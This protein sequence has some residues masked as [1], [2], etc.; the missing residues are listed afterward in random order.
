MTTTNKTPQTKQTI[1]QGTLEHFTHQSDFS[2]HYPKKTKDPRTLTAKHFYNQVPSGLVKIYKTTRAGATTALSAQS[3]KHNELF[4][5]VARTNKNLTGTVIE[6]TANII[7][8]TLNI[9]HIQANAFCPKIQQQI[10]KYPT[11][12]KLGFIPLPCNTCKTLPCPIKDT[13]N[14]PL[15]KTNGFALTYSKLMTLMVSHGKNV[16]LLMEKICKAK[17]VIFDEAQTLQEGTNVSISLWKRKNNYEY[18]LDLAP[19][20]K[21]EQAFPA[22]S[23]LL[24]KAQEIIRSAQPAIEGLKTKALTNHHRKHLAVTVTNP[25]YERFIKEQKA[26]KAQ[27]D[28]DHTKEQAQ[29]EALQRLHPDM[30]PLEIRL[31]L[32]KDP[33]YQLKEALKSIMREDIA[34]NEIVKIQEI[35]ISAI[36]KPK[37]YQLSEEQLVTL[38]KLLLIVN[39]DFFTVSYTKSFSGEEISLQAQDTLMPKAIRAFILRLLKDSTQ[40]R[41]IFTTATFG[42]LSPEKLLDLPAMQTYVWGDPMDTSSKLLVVADKFRISPY[43]FPSKLKD[44]NATIQAIT[45]KYG[46]HNVKVCTMNKDW[47]SRLEQFGIKSTYYQSDETEGVPSR[48]RIWIFVGLAQKPS[49]SKDALAMT[50]AK[51]YDNPLGLQE[52]EF[53]HYVSQQLRE[54][55][56]AVNTYQAVSRAKDQIGRAHV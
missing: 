31:M 29:I 33:N 37:E 15:E 35:L 7:K 44:I 23:R 51:Y 8:Q 55:S 32:A 28:I 42:T 30:S 19:Y 1:K 27:Q 6:Q 43:N 50:L 21:L 10:K 18:T 52:K 56:V 45:A 20:A 24:K 16:K 12:E 39:S 14:T 38:S 54:D 13:C 41:I 34:F 46:E 25:S 48:K 11:I 22:V 49:N 4:V 47:S 9:Q 36:L 40:K 17:N 53:L 26:F 2:E 3:I 5:A